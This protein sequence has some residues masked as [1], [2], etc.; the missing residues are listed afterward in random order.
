[1]PTSFDKT[2]GQQEVNKH[3]VHYSF[4]D[5]SGNNDM[6][7]VFSE[8]NQFQLGETQDIK[9]REAELNLRGISDTSFRI[10]FLLLL[11]YHQVLKLHFFRQGIFTSYYK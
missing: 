1:M 8:Q 4:W 2:F 3:V 10:A 5:T 9:R 11:P 7:L 6:K